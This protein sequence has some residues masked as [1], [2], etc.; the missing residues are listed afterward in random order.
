MATW[1]E[2]GSLP[3]V[4][5]WRRRLSPR[6][7]EYADS[8]GTVLASMERNKA[9]RERSVKR[10]ATLT[11]GAQRYRTIMRGASQFRTSPD[12]HLA[13]ERIA[14]HGHVSLL[15]RVPDDWAATGSQPGAGRESTE[16]PF[17][18]DS[19]WYSPD[20]VRLNACCIGRASP[21]RILSFRNDTTQVAVLRFLVPERP[22]TDYVRQPTNFEI[23]EA[24]LCR[25]ATDLRGWLP[26]LFLGFEVLERINT[27]VHG[28]G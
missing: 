22:Y 6:L 23:G 9:E 28:G 10:G 21:W 14:S 26:F 24:L 2:V 1:A 20:G 19:E 25:E 17:G 12:A 11:V 13:L 7:F 3:G 18:P 15:M 8:S 16:I 4:R 5:I 27:V